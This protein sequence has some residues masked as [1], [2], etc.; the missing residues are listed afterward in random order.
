MLSTEGTIAFA[1]MK[2]TLGLQEAVSTFTAAFDKDVF[3]R[4]LSVH[5][6][7]VSPT[8]HCS[9]LSVVHGVQ[10]EKLALLADESAYD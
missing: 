7:I 6:I 3:S 9:D 10:P 2:P 1:I 4:Q 5:F 8:L